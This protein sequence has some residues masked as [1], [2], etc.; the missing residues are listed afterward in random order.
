MF[1]ASKRQG[2]MPS[3]STQMIDKGK[4][5]KEEEDH[6]E[7]ERYFEVIHIDSDEENETRI[8]NSL[9]QDKNA[10]I[11]ELEVELESSKDVIHFL[12]IHNKQMSGEQAIYEARALKYQKEAQR[13]QVNL[14]E[15]MGSYE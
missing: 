15:Y 12:Q 4:Q 9:L 11:K 1:T 7:E 2:A 13:A 3:S 10:Q 5:V 8:A 14:E 6:H